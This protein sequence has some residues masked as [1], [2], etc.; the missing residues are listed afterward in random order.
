MVKIKFCLTLFAL[1]FVSLAV[2][3]CTTPPPTSSPAGQSNCPVN[4]TP[5]AA[6]IAL[7]ESVKS[8]NTESIKC[9][10]SKAT[11]ELANFM[12]GTYK[13]PVEKVL[14][15]GMTE[16]A[17]SPTLPAISNEKFIDAVKGTVD[18]KLANGKAEQI[19]FVKE[20]G[21][22]KLA[23]GEVMQ[24][25]IQISQPG[26]TNPT[27]N[28]GMT[29]TNPQPNTQPQPQPNKDNPQ[30]NPNSPKVNKQPQPTRPQ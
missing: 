17:I 7:F 25:K 22:W 26:G 14:E 30:P 24:G 9:N 3:A 11:I 29:P 28:P 4:A 5:T 10:M 2:V 16:S 1:A 6:Y 18:V 20:D 23:F 19:P 27:M 21:S 12:A 13:K 15:N 8:K